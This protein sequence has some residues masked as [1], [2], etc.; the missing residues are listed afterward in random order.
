MLLSEKKLNFFLKKLKHFDNSLNNRCPDNFERYCIHIFTIKI[1]MITTCVAFTKIQI[2]IIIKFTVRVT[3][4]IVLNT[5]SI[6]IRTT[7]LLTTAI[8][9]IFGA[10]QKILY[11][12]EYK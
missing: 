5:Y 3:I 1:T 4:C 10:I 12:G 11:S 7:N 8:Y 6:V 9:I 2:V